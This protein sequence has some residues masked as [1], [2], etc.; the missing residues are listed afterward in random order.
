MQSFR[1]LSSHIEH[2]IAC[3]DVL[4]WTGLVS[5]LAGSD[6]AGFAEGVGTAAK[7]N[8]PVAVAVNSACD[9]IVSDIYNNR[10]RIIQSSGEWVFVLVRFVLLEVCLR[11]C[12]F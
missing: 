5:T 1:F 12:V 7:F 8:N 10:V 4:C 3:C 6:S 11:E 9:V 2:W